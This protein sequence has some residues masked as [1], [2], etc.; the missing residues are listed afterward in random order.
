MK[1]PPLT[2]Q[3]LHHRDV[4][5]PWLTIA[6][7]TGAGVEVGTL[8]GGYAKV[9]AST[10]AGRLHCVDLWQRQPD[11]VYKDGANAVAEQAYAQA[12]GL[13]EPLGVNLIRCDSVKA[14]EMFEDEYLDFV[15]LDANHA[16]DAIR[17]DI[18]AW[19]PKVKV[20][21]LFCG[22]DFY[23]RYDNDTNSDAQTAV[24]EFSERVQQYPQITWC[25]SW[26]FIKTE[27]MKQC[28]PNETTV[29]KI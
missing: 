15:Y 7:L 12:R 23:I 3:S 5:G 1:F 24:L 10:W 17:A 9:I 29:P 8:F 14:A 28:F 4:L 27:A 2:L 20:G 19:F 11:S 25:S 13:L 21:G 18:R 22:H 16:V 26:F 6:G